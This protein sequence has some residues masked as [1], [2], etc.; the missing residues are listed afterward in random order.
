MSRSAQGGDHIRINVLNVH[1]PALG[2]TRIYIDHQC[3]LVLRL[4]VHE[5]SV[6]SR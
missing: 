3:R 6:S 4:C 2:L 1:E 5:I